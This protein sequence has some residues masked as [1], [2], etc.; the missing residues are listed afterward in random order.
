MFTQKA[1]KSAIVV[2]G[3][4]GDLAHRKILPA[5][6]KLHINGSLTEDSIIIGT[7]RTEFTSEHYR[8]H[9]EEFTR[10]FTEQVYYYSGLDGIR[11]FITSKGEYERIV[12][13]LAL[14]PK[15]YTK[16]VGI[17]HREGFGEEA[18]FVIEKPFG[19]DLESAKVLNDELAGYYPEEQIYRIDHYLA[20]EAVQNILVFRFANAIFEPIWN[21]QYIESIQINAYEE[22]GVEGRGS[23]YDGAGVIRD[24]IQN[25]LTQLLCLI[26]MDAPL[27][28]Q[29]EDITAKKIEVLRQLEV[30]N[31]CRHQCIDYRLEEGVDKKSHTETFAQIKLS[32]NNFRWNEV[33]IYIRA[34]KYM[35]RKGTEIGIR[36]KSIPPLLY[37]QFG[38]IENNTIIFKIQPSAGIVIDMASK[39][40]GSD[41]SLTTT[42]FSFC[43]R[44]NFTE[45]IPEAYQKLLLDAINRE[46]TLFVTAAENELS[47]QLYAESLDAGDIQFYER[48]GKPNACTD[49]EWIAFENYTHLC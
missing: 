39:I 13:F 21:S 25:H 32:L 29:S 4:S 37:N 47:W 10:E 24:M 6:H 36:F 16:T 5:L 40:P 27:S 20:K 12:F 26:T 38:N 42:N 17:L 18:V 46:R 44:D 33:P 19:Y 30:E 35:D 45:E 23:Y 9:F 41:M 8:S 15:A 2:I 11:D 49:V 43:Y 7:G 1:P 28:L 48:G 34:G 22:I 14:P 31:T 3:A